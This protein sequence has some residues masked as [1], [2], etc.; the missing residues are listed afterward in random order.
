MWRC[1]TAS[2]V[3][4][5][6]RGLILVYFGMQG[7]SRAAA[8]GGHRRW[9]QQLLGVLGIDLVVHGQARTGAKL[10]VANHVV[11][12]HRGR[13]AVVPSRFVSKAEVG[14]WPWWAL[15]TAARHALPP[16]RTPA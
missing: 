3:L 14:R 7:M 11:V 12:G 8:H 13:D 2:G 5:I 9:A 15:V 6:L 10:V 16:T 1:C 4:H